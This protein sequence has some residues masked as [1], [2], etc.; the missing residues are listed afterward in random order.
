M[1]VYTG[2]CSGDKC[3]RRLEIFNREMVPC[4]GMFL[5]SP[6][7]VYVWCVLYNLE[8]EVITLLIT[9]AEGV[10]NSKLGVT[11]LGIPHFITDRQQNLLI[12]RKLT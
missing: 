12:D 1:T 2:E 6:Y 11:I 7:P 3:Y 10:Y 9:Q 4:P 8:P 5:S